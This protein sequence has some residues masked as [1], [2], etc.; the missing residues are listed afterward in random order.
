MFYDNT[1]EIIGQDVAKAQLRYA[2]EQNIPALLVGPAGVGKNALIRQIARE[3]K[4]E[5]MRANL[6]GNVTV[7]E[8]V[9]KWLV[10]ERG[11][12]TWQD[13]IV[14]FCMKHGIMS[15]WDEINMA[16][17]EILAVTHAVTDDDRTM[18]L[19]EKDNEEIHAHKDFRIVATMNP[20]YAGTKELNKALLSR[21]AVIRMEHPSVETETQVLLDRCKHLGIVD[22]QVISEFAAVVRAAEKN[23]DVYFTY[24]V[25]ES[26][27]WANFLQVFSFKEAWE[28]AVL[29][30]VPEDDRE[31]VI[32]IYNRMFNDKYL[33]QALSEGSLTNYMLQLEQ[34][35]LDL[36]KEKEALEARKV[37]LIGE[38][39]AEA[40][41]RLVQ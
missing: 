39:I 36:K 18:R 21:F 11:I 20:D 6:N 34:R 24:T 41:K 2:M 33:N 28:F 10:K 27:F 12:M 17:A 37:S 38:V 16:V 7:D 25:R 13:G 8:F 15:V 26:I 32:G 19:I 1:A 40:A 29:N 9:G 4:Q 14:P 22:A 31:F 23:N 35:E 3:R 30:K 5:V